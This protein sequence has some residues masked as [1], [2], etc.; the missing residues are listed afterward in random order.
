LSSRQS[1]VPHSAGLLHRPISRQLVQLQK[2]GC[3]ASLLD[4]GRIFSVSFIGCSAQFR[5][6]Y[7]YF[8]SVAVRNA[9]WRTS[10]L[11]GSSAFDPRDETL[12]C[13]APTRPP[14][15]P[16]KPQRDTFAPLRHPQSPPPTPAHSTQMTG[17]RASRARFPSPEWAS[18]C[19]GGFRL[20]GEKCEECCIAKRV[21]GRGRSVGRNNWER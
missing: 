16:P 18:F 5:G 15:L 11:S 10:V 19:S 9:G 6:G 21:G 2:T 8:A 14:A 3:S 4:G 7:V 17:V 13:P 20:R 12:T 1:R